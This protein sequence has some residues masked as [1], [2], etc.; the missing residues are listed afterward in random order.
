M[1]RNNP[2]R[3]QQSG[4]ILLA[5]LLVAVITS[6]TLVLGGLNNR[7]SIYLQERAELHLQMQEAKTNL[8]AHAAYSH[9]LNNN[10]R[11]PGFFPCPDTD[12]LPLNENL[13]DCIAP[14]TV[15][16][17]PQIGRL[18]TH[19]SASEPD[20]E[21]NDRYANIDQQFWLVVAPRYYYNT[22]TATAVSNARRSRDRTSTVSTYA[23]LRLTLDGTT[24]YVALIIAPGEAL[25]TQHR[26]ASPTTASEYL[27]SQISSF[28]FQS[29]A[30]NSAVTNDVVI[31]ITLQEYLNA[32]GPSVA[33]EMKRELDAAG[34]TYTSSQTTFRGYMTNTADHSW[35]KNTTTTGTNR[36]QWSTDTTYTRLTTTTARINFNGCTNVRYILTY[37]GGITRDVIGAGC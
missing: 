26:S 37:G 2:R 13:P 22:N 24:G 35:L 10:A 23:N 25:A 33:N 30:T 21:F 9:L 19:L 29:E 17:T 11:G 5:L 6:S 34:G 15:I 4:F 12:N 7:Q 8:L 18:P 20:F 28:V 1:Y 3:L 36:E 32:V 16:T 14:A 31:G 27:E